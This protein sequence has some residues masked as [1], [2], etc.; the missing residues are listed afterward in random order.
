MPRRVLLLMSQLPQDPSSGAPRSVK[1][2][3]ELLASRGF[4][5]ECVATTATEQQ[6]RGDV[7][8]ILLRA[9]SVRPEWLSDESRREG[10]IIRFEERGVRHH[11]L[12]TGEAGILQWNDEL[13]RA[14]NAMLEERL[15]A[16]KPDVLFT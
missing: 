13:D 15:T 12:N 11:L 2:I 10:G 3:G 8:D 6:S 9:G 14:F 4:E 5:V 16:F 1:N 7:I